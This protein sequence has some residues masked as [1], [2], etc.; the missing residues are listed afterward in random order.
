MEIE[1]FTPYQ[2]GMFYE[3]FM[4]RAFKGSKTTTQEMRG[5]TIENI[6]RLKENI[7]SDKDYDFYYD[8]F[9]KVQEHIIKA[10]NYYLSKQKMTEEQKF[11]LRLQIIKI[12]K[13]M[14]P[15]DLMKIIYDCLELTN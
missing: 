10:L 12:K 1:N 13:S 15:G 7:S 6:Y 14:S 11:E 4:K 9:D 5:S 2:H 3:N 8:Q